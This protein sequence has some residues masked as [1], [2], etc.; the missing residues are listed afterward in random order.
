MTGNA[1]VLSRPARVGRVAGRDLGLDE[2]AEELLGGPPLGLGGDEQFGCEAAHRAESEP[3]K[4]GFEIGGQG[5]C[6]GGHDWS[7]MA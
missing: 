6:R 3:S 2:G 5:R 4:S 1:A 7:P